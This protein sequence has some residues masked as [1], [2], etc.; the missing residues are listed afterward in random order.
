MLRVRGTSSTSIL[1]EMLSKMLLQHDTYVVLSYYAPFLRQPVG[2][3]VGTRRAVTPHAL[4]AR[5]MIVYSYRYIR[6]HKIPRM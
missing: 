3:N 1:R 6:A 5:V 2:T 4:R